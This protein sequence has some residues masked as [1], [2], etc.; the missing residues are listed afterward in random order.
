M[1]LDPQVQIKLI[2]MSDTKAEYISRSKGM[3][4]E[5]ELNAYLEQFKKIY[6]ELTKTV[7]I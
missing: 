7:N 5:E 3:S 4:E 1:A 6:G 2:E